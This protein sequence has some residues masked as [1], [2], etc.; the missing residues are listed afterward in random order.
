MQDAPVHCLVVVNEAI[1]ASNIS[2]DSK[3]SQQHCTLTSTHMLDK[4]NSH[5]WHSDWHSD[6]LGKH[7]A[8]GQHTA[9]CY[10]P[11]LGPVWCTQSIVF[12]VTGGSAVTRWC[13]SCVFG[14]KHAAFKWKR[15]N[16]WFPIS[17]GSAEAGYV[18]LENKVPFDCLLSQ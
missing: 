11:F 13:V 9:G 10:A 18:R 12:T 5:F 2:W 17:P 14:K 1:I 3:I 16:F 6:R 7:Q 15:R 4:N 8:W